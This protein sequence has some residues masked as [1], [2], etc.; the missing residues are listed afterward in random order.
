MERD[1]SDEEQPYDGEQGQS[2]LT[3][4][5]AGHLAAAGGAVAATLMMIAVLVYYPPGKAKLA[6]DSPAQDLTQSAA[7]EFVT[8]STLG[9]NALPQIV[10]TEAPAST[11]PS[12]VTE[13]DDILDALPAPVPSPSDDTA[14]LI[15]VAARAERCPDDQHWDGEQCVR[16]VTLL[17]LPRDG[18]QRGYWRTEG[19]CCTFGKAWDGRRCA[20]HTDAQG[21]PSCPFGTFGVYPE[22]IPD[23]SAAQCPSGKRFKNGRCVEHDAANDDQAECAQG[24]YSSEGHC[25]PRGTIWNGKRCLRNAGLQPSCPRGQI[26]IFPDCREPGAYAGQKCPSGT[27]G[28]PPNCTPSNRCPPGLTGAPPN[29]RRIEVTTCPAGTRGHYPNCQ[30]IAR[31]CPPGTT[32]VPPVCRRNNSRVPCPAGTVG[33]SGR[34]VVLQPPRATV[35]PR[36][37]SPIVVPPKVTTSP[38]STR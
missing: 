1:H 33:S 38:F 20:T 15:D 4:R 14:G 25:C 6:D 19:H 27:E 24:F 16:K 28:T 3:S 23:Q 35:Q 29:C 12:D 30:P 22:C 26:G 5:L 34:C 36:S 10:R 7:P 9:Q 11:E 2:W 18:C 21:Q 8:A 37:P 32:G 31:V 13:P 17:P